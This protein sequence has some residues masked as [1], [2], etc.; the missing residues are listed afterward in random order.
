MHMSVSSCIFFN[1]F[2]CIDNAVGDALD[3]F[4]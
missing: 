3:S 4:V 2:I 1:T